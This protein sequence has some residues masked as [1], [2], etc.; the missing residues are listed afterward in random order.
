MPSRGQGQPRKS[1]TEPGP[2]LH[3]PPALSTPA[4]SLHRLPRDPAA[5]A[6]TLYLSTVSSKW[7]QAS[8]S[9]SPLRSTQSHVLTR[10]ST[11][12]PPSSRG[13]TSHTH[14]QA[15]IV[16]ELATP[17]SSPSLP[18]NSQAG[19]MK[20]QTGS[21][22]ASA[23]HHT[24]SFSLCTWNKTHTPPLPS[25]IQP[26][27]ASLHTHAPTPPAFPLPP[28]PP[29]AAFPRSLCRMCTGHRAPL[30]SLVPQVKGLT[31]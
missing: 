18:H 29:A 21:Y 28:A 26:L 25:H 3:L 16:S 8:E 27:P 1:A 9:Y 30:H 20:M 17:R 22:H 13:T 10:V 5:A 23:H 24:W 15:S 4:S 31:V 7:H 12:S 11:R 6:L 2:S 14:T 19:L